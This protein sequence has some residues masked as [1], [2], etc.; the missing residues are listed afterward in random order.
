MTTFRSFL[1][2]ESTSRTTING[3]SFSSIGMHN[4]VVYDGCTNADEDVDDDDDE[5]D[6]DEDVIGVL[7][8]VI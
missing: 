1:N 7:V 8:E 2:L 4:D 3:H 5:D 6:D